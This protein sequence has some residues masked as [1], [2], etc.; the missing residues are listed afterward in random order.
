MYNKQE[1]NDIAYDGENFSLFLNNIIVEN[2]DKSIKVICAKILKLHS[3][4]DKGY[5]KNITKYCLEALDISLKNS[6]GFTNI[7]FDEYEFIKQNDYIFT[8]LESL[9]EIVDISF[10]VLCILSGPVLNSTNLLY[11]I[12]I[13]YIFIL[14][15]IIY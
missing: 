13:I 6:S 2:R 7:S 8:K 9:N 14:K 4:H 15:I 3:K 10:L 11:I 12:Y 1:E 5:T